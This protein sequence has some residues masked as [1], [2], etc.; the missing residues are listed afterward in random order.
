MLTP[1][2]KS[3]YHGRWRDRDK[4]HGYQEEEEC[5]VHSIHCIASNAYNWHSIWRVIVSLSVT[6][7][8][9][10]IH[11]HTHTHTDAYSY[12]YI[13]TQ[14]Q[15]KWPQAERVTHIYTYIPNVSC[16][17]KFWLLLLGI[18]EV[19]TAADS[20]FVLLLLHISLLLFLLVLVLLL[21]QQSKNSLTAFA[22]HEANSE[23][24]QTPW[25]CLMPIRG[26]RIH[27]GEYQ[28]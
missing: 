3:P 6:A 1:V 18:C 22:H 28:S 19:C 13:H 2:W 7:C 4:E 25:C 14:T 26:R 20:C 17:T 5:Q 21:L 16:L 11:T 9:M 10:H 23:E 8:S 12:T 24:H 15:T 27:P